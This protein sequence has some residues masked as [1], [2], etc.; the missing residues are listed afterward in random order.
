[1]DILNKNEFAEMNGYLRLMQVY[2]SCLNTLAVPQS[3]GS[4]LSSPSNQ[5]ANGGTHPHRRERR[6]KKKSDFVARPL[7]RS[8][9][10]LK[11]DSAGQGSALKEE[12]SGGMGRGNSLGSG[13][14]LFSFTSIS[15]KEG[16][17]SPFLPSFLSEMRAVVN[18]ITPCPRPPPSRPPTVEW[19]SASIPFTIPPSN[20]QSS[21]RLSRP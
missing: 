17:E 21:Q 7:M 19:T 18:L 8:E 13:V 1:M 15:I 4:S 12:R 3:F 11:I 10:R 20:E 14:V 5:S 6:R 9:L 16:G 2:N